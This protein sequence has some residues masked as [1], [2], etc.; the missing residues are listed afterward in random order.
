[1]INEKKRL[2]YIDRMRGMA[3]ILVVIGH[4]IQYNIINGQDINLYSMIYSFHMPLF[5]FI[6][7]YVLQKFL[8]IENSIDSVIFVWKKTR[9]LLLPL[10]SWGIMLVIFNNSINFE[11]Y[12]KIY[13]SILS[14]IIHPQLW[15]LHT[16]FLLMVFSLLFYWISFYLNKKMLI[17]R[18]LIIYLVLIASIVV[19]FK[20]F[21]NILPASFVLYS[22]FF[23]FGVFLV[24]YTKLLKLL[25]NSIVSNIALIVFIVLV[26]NYNFNESNLIIMKGLKIIISFTAIIVLYKLAKMEIFSKAVDNFI[27]QSGKSSLAI[28][29]IHFSFVHIYT[30]SFNSNLFFTFLTLLF[31]SVVII[32]PIFFI[33]KI[34]KTFPYI[35][36][37]L[38]GTQLKK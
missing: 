14:Q 2:D 16:L 21:F 6:S 34:I 27:I 30:V 13:L 11:L 4:L 28:Y 23:M 20:L 37:F 33:E 5:M 26:G 24:K 17:L 25:E 9:A 7:G 36:F 22:I 35:S 32:I 29:I 18:D 19:T 10:F 8:R 3:I 12:K 31:I 1:M 38:L 15:F